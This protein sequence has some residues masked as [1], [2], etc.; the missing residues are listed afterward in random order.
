MSL[1]LA[2]GA[3]SR[4]AVGGGIAGCSVPGAGGLLLVCWR[5]RVLLVC[6]RGRVLLLRCRGGVRRRR[7]Q[8]EFF[9]QR[10]HPCTGPVQGAVYL[11]GR[12]CELD[13]QG[14]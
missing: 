12:R 1:G 5:G 9:L 10:Q 8:S 2:E 7:E 6:W 11:G 4:R 3:G 13:P 14:V